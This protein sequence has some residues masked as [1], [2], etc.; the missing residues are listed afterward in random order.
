MID[1]VILNNL[2]DQNKAP[3]ELIKNKAKNKGLLDFKSNNQLINEHSKHSTHNQL[4]TQHQVHSHL[5][6]ANK[7][8]ALCHSKLKTIQPVRK[9]VHFIQCQKM[10]RRSET[11]GFKGGFIPTEIKSSDPQNKTPRQLHS[12][13]VLRTGRKVFPIHDSPKGHQ[14]KER[15]QTHLNSQKLRAPSKSRMHERS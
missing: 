7:H 3:S 1:N 4:R 12:G 11:R 8:S 14:H 2:A 9:T 15:K 10:N 13:K 6:I 5:K